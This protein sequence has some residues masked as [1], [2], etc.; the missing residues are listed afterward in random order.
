MLSYMWLSL[1]IRLPI[2][3]STTLFSSELGRVSYGW[4]MGPDAL[5]P[6]SPRA[7]AQTCS[8]EFRGA[9]IKRRTSMT[10]GIT[11]PTRL[12]DA[13]GPSPVA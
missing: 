3:A 8:R 11:P 10:D 5:H 6:L 9:G 13:N 4:I 1:R 2:I 7:F 12:L